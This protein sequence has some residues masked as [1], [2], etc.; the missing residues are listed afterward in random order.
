MTV[1]IEHGRRNESPIEST[2]SDE[3]R[4][5][6]RITVC[7]EHGQLHESHMESTMSDEDERWRCELSTADRMSVLSRSAMSDEERRGKRMTVC[8]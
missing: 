6:R 3:E 8:V 5:G 4:R 1:C 2:M 7:V